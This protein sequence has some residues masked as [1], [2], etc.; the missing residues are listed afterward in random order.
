MLKN[1]KAF[2]LIEM[3]IVLFVITILLL[4]TIPNVTKH[5]ASI[6]EKGCEGLKNMVQAEIQAYQID[7]KGVPKSINDL[8]GEYLKEEP[9][10]PDGRKIEISNGKAV[11]ES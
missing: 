3:M 5:Q 7:G 9:I 2:T 8:K 1:E 10:C 11:I 4:I 6:S